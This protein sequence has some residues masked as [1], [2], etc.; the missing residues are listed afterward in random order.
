MTVHAPIRLKRIGSGHGRRESF[1]LLLFDA[2]WKG[3]ND[4]K[5]GKIAAP[6]IRRRDNSGRLL[7]S[8]VQGQVEPRSRPSYPAKAGYPV[9]RGLSVLSLTSLEYWIT[10]LPPSLKLRRTCT[11]SPSKPSA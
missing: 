6:L 1:S 9:R 4:G 10:R 5:G 8:D 7:G 2:P 11:E 3:D